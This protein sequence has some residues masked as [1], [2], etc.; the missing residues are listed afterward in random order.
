MN[1]YYKS[2]GENSIKNSITNRGDKEQEEI[3]EKEKEIAS[4]RVF[5]EEVGYKTAYDRDQKLIR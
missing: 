2:N 4:K 3:A 5:L 1:R